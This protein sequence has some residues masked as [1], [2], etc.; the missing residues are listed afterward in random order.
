MINAIVGLSLIAA[1]LGYDVMTDGRR[2]R[3]SGAHHAET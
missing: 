1:F 3:V 2:I